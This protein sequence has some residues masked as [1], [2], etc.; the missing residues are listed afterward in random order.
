MKYLYILLI[1]YGITYLL[2]YAEIFN[3]PR[4]FLIKKSLFVKKVLKCQYCSGFWAGVILSAFLYTTGCSDNFLL[5]TLPV[6]SLSFSGL[7]Y[8]FLKI[9]D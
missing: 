7:L 3:I 4:K 8:D 2:R 5:M 6:A 9:A 1:C